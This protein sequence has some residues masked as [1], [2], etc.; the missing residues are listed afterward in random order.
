MNANISIRGFVVGP[1]WWPA[2]VECFK[3]LD[4]DLTRED[5]RFLEPGT[6]RDHILAATNDGDFQHCTI[7]Q[8]E[9]IIETTR[10]D[11]A[12][13]IVKRIR[14][15]PLDRFPSIADCLH[16]GPDWWPEYGEDD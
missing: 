16:P 10:R 2:G 7:A 1:V 15:W 6:L 8:G 14:S 12:S 13:A 9:L 4:Y 3:P 5:A 11:K